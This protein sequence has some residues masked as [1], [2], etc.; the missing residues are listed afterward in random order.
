MRTRFTWFVAILALVAIG[1]LVACSSKYSTSS[2]GLVVVPSYASLVMESFSLNLGNGHISEI[3]NI[4]G[5]PIPGVPTAVVLDP[6]GAFAYVIIYQNTSVP[7]ALPGSLPFKS[8]R[9]ENW[10]TSAPL[11]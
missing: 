5:P 10:P 1:F 2:N 8:P 11:Q 7:A 6:A 9:M 4:N 3:N